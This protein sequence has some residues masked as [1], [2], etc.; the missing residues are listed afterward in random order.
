MSAT[1]TTHSHTR[2][3]SGLDGVLSLLRELVPDLAIQH[4]TGTALADSTHP[5]SVGWRKQRSL[6][7]APA[8]CVEDTDTT[9]R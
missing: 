4:A 3:I 1:S 5:D 6:R 8:A 9:P 7:P 2:A